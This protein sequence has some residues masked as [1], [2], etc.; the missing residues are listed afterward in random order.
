MLFSHEDVN[1]GHTTGEWSAGT[2]T[3]ISNGKN[4]RKN[5]ATY[6]SKGVSAAVR[7]CPDADKNN[8][9]NCSMQKFQANKFNVYET[10]D[11][12]RYFN[13]I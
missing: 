13:V 3:R 12:R 8:K 6:F 4:L 9:S 11:W 7:W 5:N 2:I 10:Y 1:A